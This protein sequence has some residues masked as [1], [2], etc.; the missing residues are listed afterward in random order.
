LKIKGISFVNCDGFEG[1]KLYC[2]TIYTHPQSE[3]EIFIAGSGASVHLSGSIEGIT[4]LKEYQND[5]VTVSD[6]TSF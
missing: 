4:N 2:F 6:G 5:R 3:H 1:F